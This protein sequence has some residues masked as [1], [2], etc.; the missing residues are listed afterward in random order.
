[1]VGCKSAMSRRRQYVAGGFLVLMVSGLSGCAA[2]AEH[3]VGLAGDDALAP[4]PPAPRCVS[5]QATV[6]R[7]SVPPLVL[8][9]SPELAWSEAVVAL[10]AMDRTAV[11]ERED[12]YVRAEVVSPWGVYTDDV[13]LVFRPAQGLIDLRSTAR[14]GYY[15]FQ[16]NRDRVERLRTQLVSEGVVR[17]LRGSAVDD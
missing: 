12:R 3:R 11:V 16:V 17:P 14:L 9:G 15:D 2:L 13:E 6:N 10:E 1:M 4:C 7:H 5:S 8:V